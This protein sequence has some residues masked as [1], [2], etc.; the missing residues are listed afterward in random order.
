MPGRLSISPLTYPW[1]YTILDLMSQLSWT[2]LFPSYI[3]TEI[4]LA[5]ISDQITGKKSVCRRS[6]GTEVLMQS[7]EP[8]S[9]L[10]YMI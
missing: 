7:T 9:L 8:G 5:Y 1:L 4:N 10:F 6:E 3:E 2:I